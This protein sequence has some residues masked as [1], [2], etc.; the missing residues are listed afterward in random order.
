MVH[1]HKVKTDKEKYTPIVK[2][3]HISNST[4]AS[5]NIKI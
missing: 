3:Y 1:I 2:K 4:I 5:N